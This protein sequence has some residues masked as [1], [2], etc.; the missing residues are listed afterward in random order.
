M[1]DSMLPIQ[2]P[3]SQRERD[4][5]VLLSGAAGYPVVVLGPVADALA[6]LRAAPA[7]SELDGEAAAR[8][9]FRRYVLPGTGL[10]GGAPVAAPHQQEAVAGHGHHDGQGPTVVLPMTAPAGPR[11]ARPRPRLPWPGRWQ[12]L[13]AACGAAAAVIVCAA[14]L[15]GAFSGPGGQPARPGYQSSPQ[16]ASASGKRPMSSVLGTATARPV[17]RPSESGQAVS[18]AALCHQYMEFFTHPGSPANSSAEN[19]VVR[20]LSRLAG[21]WTRIMGYCARQFGAGTSWSRPDFHGGPGAPVPGG[22]PDRDGRGGPV[23]PRLG[24]AG[25]GAPAVRARP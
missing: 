4:L 21:G 22:Q 24:R 15:A 1:P 19:D 23:M 14:A 20:Q 11:H 13:T 2:G 9:A 12:V 7:P 17:P 10:A 6:A 5:D 18:P 25:P 16:P 3:A 8:A